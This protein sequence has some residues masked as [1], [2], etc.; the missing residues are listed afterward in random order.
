ML[1]LLAS[2][3]QETRSYNKGAYYFISL[4]GVTRRQGVY[5]EKWSGIDTFE[6]QKLLQSP[7][8]PYLPTWRGYAGSFH[9]IQNWGENFGTRIRSYFVPKQN[10]SYTF[11]IASNGASQLFL[12]RDENPDHKSLIA[13]V[14]GIR[15]TDPEQ[16]DKYDTQKS[17]PVNLEK[18][19]YY[20]IETLMKEFYGSDHISV[21]VTMPNGQFITPISHEY[22]WTALSSY[23]EQQN[24]TAQ[25]HLLE[26]VARA[27][28]RAGAYAGIHSA[29][30]AG[31]KTGAEAGAKA[32]SK[33]GAEAGAQ[34]AA[35][36]ARETVTKTF[37]TELL[38]FYRH[39]HVVNVHLFGPDGNLIVK[40]IAGQ[41]PRVSGAGVGGGTTTTTGSVDPSIGGGGAS[42]AGGGGGGASAGTT[43]GAGAAGGSAAASSSGAAAAAAAGASAAGSS[44]SGASSSAS[45]ASKVKA[46][47]S[48]TLSSATDVV[49]L[50]EDNKNLQET[51]LPST[52][53]GFLNP[54]SKQGAVFLYRAPAGQ[55]PGT[56]AR[57]LVY[58]DGTASKLVFDAY[59]TIRSLDLPARQINSSANLC[60]KAMQSHVTLRGPCHYF[61]IRQ[62]KE[63]KGKIPFMLESSCVPGYFLTQINYRYIL[64]RDDGSS[65]FQYSHTHSTNQRPAFVRSISHKSKVEDVHGTDIIIDFPSAGGNYLSRCSFLF[66]P[67]PSDGNKK[68]NCK[69]VLAPLNTDIPGQSRQKTKSKEEDKKPAKCVAINFVNHANIP[70]KLFSSLKH[71]GY[72]VKGE[73][74]RLKAIIKQPNLHRHV[75]FQAHDPSGNNT[76][77]L[78]GDRSITVTPSDDCKEYIPIE[79]TSI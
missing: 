4:T 63:I 69:N 65:H 58:E 21:A 50:G 5:I 41:D 74:F 1:D 25:A 79:V 72:L 60:F 46:A 73:S 20:Y 14:T 39:A 44:V 68:M 43:A 62:G 55:D 75:V 40:N 12:S 37:N 49:A 36:A 64:M 45:A 35:A 10:G 77:F 29:M 52:S 13:E 8:Y 18:G 33:I 9:Q 56:V 66:V 28:A 15:Y 61:I 24:A 6:L 51:S 19:K 48:A 11:H 71:E 31:A 53:T 70:F 27:G 26:I 32:G 57:S 23:T 17:Y 47:N 22:L 34:A 38:K 76:M 54:A 59:Y 42:A 2:R 16:Y 7:R 30:K 78:E 67:M 3:L